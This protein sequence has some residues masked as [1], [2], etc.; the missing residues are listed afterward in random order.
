MKALSCL[1]KEITL[2]L[3]EPIGILFFFFFFL[4]LL[5]F[6][7]VIILINDKFLTKS[8]ISRKDSIN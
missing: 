1:C 3:I 5:V 4:N 6:L 8:R 7:M 2:A